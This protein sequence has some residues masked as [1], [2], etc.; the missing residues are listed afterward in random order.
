MKHFTDS[1]HMQRHTH[2]DTHVQTHTHARVHAHRRWCKSTGGLNFLLEWS[3]ILLTYSVRS[4]HFFKI[5]FI[6]LLVLLPSSLPFPSLSPPPSPAAWS[7]QCFT[8]PVTLHVLQIRL[9]VLCGPSYKIG[10][11]ITHFYSTLLLHSFHSSIPLLLLTSCHPWPGCQFSLLQNHSTVIQKHMETPQWGP[12]IGPIAVNPFWR[13]FIFMS[14][15]KI[16]C[17]KFIIN[18]AEV[19][20]H[21]LTL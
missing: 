21:S 5:C 20:Q 8:V 17:V 18:G 9:F 14:L 15:V 7:V 12:D 13:C 3:V 1:L 10:S 2:R 11:L 4:D 16:V 6:N 19:H